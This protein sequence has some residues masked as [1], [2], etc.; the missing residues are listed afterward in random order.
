MR[1]NGAWFRY[2][3]FVLYASGRQALRSGILRRQTEDSRSLQSRR[4][5]RNVSFYPCRLS[6]AGCPAVTRTLRPYRMQGSDAYS[7]ALP[8]SLACFIAGWCIGNG[9]TRCPPD[10]FPR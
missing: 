1:Q 4:Q 3:P 2:P 10:S 7:T 8:L 9:A 5:A 6:A